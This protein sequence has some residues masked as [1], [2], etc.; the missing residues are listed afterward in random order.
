LCT[1]GEALGTNG[2]PELGARLLI[3][4]RHLYQKVGNKLGEAE[5]LCARGEVEIALG[6]LK[7]AEK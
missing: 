2:Q 7:S 5:V 3:E 4:A 6:R 1:E